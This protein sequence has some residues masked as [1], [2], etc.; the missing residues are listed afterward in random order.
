MV[1]AYVLQYVIRKHHNGKFPKSFRIKRCQRKHMKDNGI[2]I[3]PWIRQ[4]LDRIMDGKEDYPIGTER[5]EG[6]DLVRTTA[7]IRP[8]QQVFIEGTGLNFSLFVDN[9]IEELMS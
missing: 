9:K 4:H 1:S 6:V 3:S 7:T 5:R 8:D 2:E